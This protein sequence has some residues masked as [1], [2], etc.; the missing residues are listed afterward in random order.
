MTTMKNP[1]LF[2]HNTIWR[3]GS[4]PVVNGGATYQAVMNDIF[5][6][7]IGVFMDVYLDDIIIYSDIKD[8]HVI[9]V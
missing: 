7:Y 3:H 9:I 2:L 6:E 5:S 4:A 8:E 1:P